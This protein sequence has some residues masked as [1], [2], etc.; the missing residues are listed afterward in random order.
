MSIFHCSS[1]VSAIDL[2][3]TQLYLWYLEGK[4]LY[5][6]LPEAGHKIVCEEGLS[7]ILLL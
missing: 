3:P 1:L 2:V 6:L 7:P 5:T 4:K